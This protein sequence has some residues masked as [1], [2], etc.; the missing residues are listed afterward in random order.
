M[1][2]AAGWMDQVPLTDKDRDMRTAIGAHSLGVL[3]WTEVLDSDESIDM[4]PVEEE[5]DNG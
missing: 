3:Y 2:I 5:P 1:S 4:R